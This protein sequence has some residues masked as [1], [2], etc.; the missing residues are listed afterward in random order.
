MQPGEYHKEIQAKIEKGS[1][2]MCFF[3]PEHPLARKNCMVA[4]G[5]HILSVKLGRWLEAGEM[6]HFEDGSPQN[7]SPENLSL[8]T[9]AALASQVHNHHVEMICPQCGTTFRTSPSHE[10]R[11]TCCSE[12]C[13]QLYFRKFE[14]S[15]EELEKLVWEM[16]TTQVAALFG[17]SDKAVEK[18]C[19]R[20][21]VAKPPRGYWAKLAAG[22]I[23]PEL[24][25][26]RE[27]AA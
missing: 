27:A 17:V 8:T 24:Q 1:G 12:P 6:V 26:S 20:L 9:R 2:Q 16:P 10:N 13:H 25:T 15:R 21:G 14:V 4:L 19:K 11:R 7:V 5:R 23:D 18:R 22:Q 3:D